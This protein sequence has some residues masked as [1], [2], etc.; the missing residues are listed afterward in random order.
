MSGLRTPLRLAALLATAFLSCAATQS[1]ALGNPFAELAGSWRGDG[2]L[3]P[4]GGDAER[5]VCRAKYD[6]SEA[7]VT[8]TIIC[9]GTDYKINAVSNLTY[10]GGTLTGS[11]KE[12]N[13][14]AGGGASGSVKGG[15]IYLRISGESFNARM[16]IDMSDDQ[17][18]VTIKQFN[19]GNGEYRHVASLNLAR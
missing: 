18:T 3:E 11:W 13:Y 9:A 7:A 5:V 6:V 19:A 1:P 12:K 10:S 4:L 15:R 8:Q 2:T 17:H 16:S 14:G